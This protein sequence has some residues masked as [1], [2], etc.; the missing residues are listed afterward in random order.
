MVATGA[1]EQ[2]E[3]MFP[4]RTFVKSN[5]FMSFPMFM[6][7]DDITII[8]RRHET[9]LLLAAWEAGY[10]IYEIKHERSREEIFNVEK[11]HSIG[12]AKRR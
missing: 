11:L 1:A 3:L 2:Q 6:E 4:D 5:V 12:L 7:K 9:A 8:K 10:Y